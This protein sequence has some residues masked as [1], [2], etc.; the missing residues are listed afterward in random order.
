MWAARVVVEG[1]VASYLARHGRPI[2][3]SYLWHEFG[4]SALLLPGGATT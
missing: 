4:D 1:D 3:Y 2:R